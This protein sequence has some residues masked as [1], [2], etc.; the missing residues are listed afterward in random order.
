MLLIWVSESSL[1]GGASGNGTGLDWR[2]VAISVP[3]APTRYGDGKTIC[4]GKTTPSGKVFQ[5]VPPAVRYL[6]RATPGWSPTL[7]S[8]K[9]A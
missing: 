9:N 2:L 3:L 8:A 6:G 1:N 7:R 5:S 4:S